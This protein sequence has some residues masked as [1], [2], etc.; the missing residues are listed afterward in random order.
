LR[1]N[2][3]RVIDL[4]RHAFPTETIVRLRVKISPSSP[5]V[6]T[7]GDPRID[8]IQESLTAAELANWYQS[9]TVFVNA[10]FGEGFGLHLLEAMACGRTLISTRFGGVGAFFDASVGYEVGYRLVEAR[11]A[12]YSGRW[13]DP[14]D[15]DLIDRMRQVARGPAE[16]ARLGQV[17][18]ER[19]GRF[20][21][22][23]TAQGLVEVLVRYGFLPASPGDH[24]KRSQ[25]QGE[26]HHHHPEA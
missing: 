12:I 4:F 5:P 19:A 20:T 1:K 16:A 8:V 7:D 15:N 13:A 25:E 18:A 24:P 23:K 6:R 14:D 26:D 9:L 3:Q 2:V 21:W 10:S 11:N 17:A 22:S